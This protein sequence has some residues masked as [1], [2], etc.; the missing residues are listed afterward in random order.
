MS[1]PSFFKSCGNLLLNLLEFSYK[2]MIITG[3]T[4]MIILAMKDGSMLN[5]LGIFA[6]RFKYFTSGMWLT[7]NE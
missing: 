5:N 4:I 6:C 3:S 7:N 1:D 2:A